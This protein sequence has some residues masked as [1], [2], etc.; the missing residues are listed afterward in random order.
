MD[1]GGKGWVADY[2]GRM[3]FFEEDLED[4]L[5]HLE[6]H[7]AK[8]A[9]DTEPLRPEKARTVKNINGMGCI[10]I[11][12]DGK[13][14]AKEQYCDVAEYFTGRHAACFASIRHFY[15][16]DVANLKFDNC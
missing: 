1:A 8:A 6:A 2:I 16:A 14:R 15:Q 12:K 3:E 4:L 7:R 11:S 5:L 10:E 9:P 13:L